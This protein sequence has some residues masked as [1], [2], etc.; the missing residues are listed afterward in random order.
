MITAA[1]DR[2]S[3]GCSNER[4][5]TNFGEAF[6]RDALPEATSIRAAFE[7]A[8]D[9]IAARERFEGLTPS[10]PT[11]Y[12]GAAMEHKLDVEGPLFTGQTLPAHPSRACGQPR[13]QCYAV[14]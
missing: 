8:R 5:L 12:F 3:F 6:I 10:L 2:T 7:K 14:Y 1:A 4:D 9:S 11:A 13:F